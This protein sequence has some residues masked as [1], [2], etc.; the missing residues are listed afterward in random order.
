MSLEQELETYRRELPGLLSQE[1]EGK[2]LLIRG[3]QVIGIW[4]TEDE[5]YKTGRERFGLTPSMVRQVQNGERRF[6]LLTHLAPLRSTA[7]CSP[8]A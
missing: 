3:Q 7:F 4:A 2:Y 6:G 1:H 5:A 8:T